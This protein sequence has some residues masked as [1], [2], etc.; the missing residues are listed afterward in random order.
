M[1]SELLFVYGSLRQ[2]A[3]HPMHRVIEQHCDFFGDARIQARL[4]EVDGYPGAVDSQH[5]NEQV[6]GELYRIREQQ[7][8]F[9]ELDE[10]EQCNDN[11]PQPHE[12][13]RC[14]RNCTL[15][16]SGQQVKAWFYL[17]THNTETLQRIDSGDWLAWCT[18]Q[19]YNTPATTPQHSN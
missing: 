13:L 16:D 6:L 18:S 12:Y 5:I 3:G 14:I 4:Y 8:L 15:L 19:H 17:F 9:R 10:Y 11:Y 1:Q 7:Q 2:A